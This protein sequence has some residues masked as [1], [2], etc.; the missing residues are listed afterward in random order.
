MRK[1]HCF[2]KHTSIQTDKTNERTCHGV[3]SLSVSEAIICFQPNQGVKIRSTLENQVR[4]HD[5]IMGTPAPELESCRCSEPE[6][7]EGSNVR[8]LEEFFNSQTC[9]LLHSR[10]SFSLISDIYIKTQK[11]PQPWSAKILAL[12][13]DS[14]PFY[15]K[16]SVYAWA[17]THACPLVENL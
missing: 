10:D 16:R 13:R 17:L 8:A 3:V 6:L 14:M 7:W 11:C 5:L 1:K 12:G 4:I 9:I 15:R 2:F